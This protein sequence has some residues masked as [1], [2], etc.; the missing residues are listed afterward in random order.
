ML[1]TGLIL[2]FL[3][4]FTFSFASDKN[5]YYQ[6]INEM[7]QSKNYAEG[8]E[9][10][11]KALKD[12]PDEPNFILNLVYFYSNNKEHSKAYSL[13]KKAVKDF[14]GNAD[15]R[16]SLVN[17]ALGF[18]W[19]FQ[20]QG[21]NSEAFGYFKE[22]YGLDPAYEWAINAYSYFLKETGENLKAIE[23]LE[24]AVVLF[25][26]NSY[27][28]RSLSW[29][30]FNQGVK[31]QEEQKLKKSSDCFK[32]FFRL[33]D[34]KNITVWSAYLYKLAHL[35]DFAT[36]FRLL[37]EAQQLFP[38]N[39]ELYE[40]G[41]WL[42]F[43]QAD[44]YSKAKKYPA[45]IEEYKTLYLYSKQ[46]EK[47]WNDGISYSKLAMMN[48]NFKLMDLISSICPYY[49]KF[50]GTQKK[51]AYQYLKLLKAA[52]P[53][54]L[55]FLYEQFKGHILYRDNK[56]AETQRAMDRSYELFLET[57]WG[58][59]YK[60]TELTIDFPLRGTYLA[61]NNENLYAI[62]HMGLQK[63]AYDFF[64]SDEQGN[65]YKPGSDSK[66][67][68][69]YYHYGSEIYSP[70][71]GIVHETDDGHPEDPIGASASQPYGNNLQ[72]LSDGKLYH[73][74]H[75]KNGSIR[76]KKGERVRKGDI[77]ALFGNSSSSS[78]HLHFG[79][80]SKDWMV[81]FPVKF[82]RYTLIKNGKRIQ[83]KQERPGQNN[84]LD[85]IEVR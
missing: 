63:Y 17:S 73:F 68:A 78:P 81:S 3:I 61:G 65:F 52:L 18:G 32:Y 5:F 71:D 20:E 79:V 13:A 72:I 19:Y 2:F 57:S 9:L 84:Q 64:G 6:K 14:P 50:T 62:T 38:N 56:V 82:N 16:R 70:V 66:N 8:I 85:V 46:Q 34:K 39:K 10:I 44:S 59:P 76:V 77:I 30:Y 31:L 21:K 69:N 75:V 48:F 49:K 53:D 58:K 42:Y 60:G 28:T 36:G 29:A 67:L 47:I 22:A 24:K 1:K 4:L 12:F 40:P 27:L 7:S 83:L 45:M 41:Y 35:K 51:E 26:A 25:P 37:K 23:I 11:K 55:N 43:H 54:E 80:F 74:Y 33:G 15:I